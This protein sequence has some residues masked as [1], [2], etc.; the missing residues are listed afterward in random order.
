MSFFS[1]LLYVENNNEIIPQIQFSFQALTFLENIQ[2]G[3]DG[4]NS[5]T[6]DG[7]IEDKH[8]S[9]SDSIIQNYVA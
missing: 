3:P 6:K 4:L 8:I 7:H 1:F 5:H 2:K 9:E